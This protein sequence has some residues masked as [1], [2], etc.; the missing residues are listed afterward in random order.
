MV[1]VFTLLW[2]AAACLKSKRAPVG[3]ELGAVG[4]GLATLVCDPGEHATDFSPLQLLT[5]SFPQFQAF[6]ALDNPSRHSS[7]VASRPWAGQVEVVRAGKERATAVRL[8]STRGSWPELKEIEEYGS[9]DTA[10]HSW[11][12][13]VD[14]AL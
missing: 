12:S 13:G 5:V 9:V 10:R 7:V 6:P 11:S 3:G 2:F 1:C 14:D 4:V 8:G